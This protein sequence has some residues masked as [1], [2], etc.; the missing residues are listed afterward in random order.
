MCTVAAGSAGSHCGSKAVHSGIQTGKACKRMAV[1]PAARKQSGCRVT[2]A[3]EV[4]RGSSPC[5]QTHDCLLT[6]L[7]LSETCFG[8]AGTAPGPV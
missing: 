1:S 4:M 2:G 8:A 7:Q 5:C 3:A 6:L